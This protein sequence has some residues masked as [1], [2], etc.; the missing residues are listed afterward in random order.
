MKGI[1][2]DHPQTKDIVVI[3]AEKEELSK[4]VLEM[5]A[6]LLQMTKEKEDLIQEK[7]YL[8]SQRESHEPLAVS[9]SVDTVELADYMSRASLKEKEISQLI[10]EKNKLV[11]EKN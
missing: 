9:Q 3:Q 7:E 4:K 10:Q 8:I 1:P 2:Y 5:K 11:Q 6:K